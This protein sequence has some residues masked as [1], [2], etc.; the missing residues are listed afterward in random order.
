MSVSRI[1]P[2]CFSVYL[3][4]IL[5]TSCLWVV[6]INTY[7]VKVGCEITKLLPDIFW[8]LIE[9]YMS[10]RTFSVICKEAKHRICLL[11]KFN[12]AVSSDL[13]CTRSVLLIFQLIITQPTGTLADWKIKHNE[14][15]SVHVTHAL[16]NTGTNIRVHLNDIQVQA[17]YLDMHTHSWL[18]W[19]RH[20]R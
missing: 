6:I 3:S 12:R 5:H 16:R 4:T 20:V 14:A 13:L 9:S 7:F 11:S 18:T 17:K 19:K 2:F 8:R 1:Y 10:G 15:M